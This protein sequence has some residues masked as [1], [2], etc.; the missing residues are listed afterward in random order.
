MG[1]KIN[2]EG[3]LIYKQRI[4]VPNQKNVKDLILDEHHKNLYAD[5]RGYH[6]LITTLRNEYLWPGMKKEVIQYLAASK[7]RV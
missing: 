6:K 3:M 7:S 4:Y 1:Y 5:H 2:H